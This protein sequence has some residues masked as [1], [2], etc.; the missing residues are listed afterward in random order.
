M[1]LAVLTLTIPQ[2]QSLSNA[3]EIPVNLRV[4]RIGMPSDWS[5]AA[6]ITFQIS[7]DNNDYRDLYHAQQNVAGPWFPY[8]VSTQVI[9]NSMLLLPLDNMGA[10]I[11]WL[12]IRSGLRSNPINQTADRTFLVGVA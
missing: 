7:P 5:A 11:G 8:E 2:A 9:P 6:P 10:H 3:L 12:K 4:V 1:A